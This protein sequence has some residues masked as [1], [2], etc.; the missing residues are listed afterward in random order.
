VP[1]GHGSY[2]LD[3]RRARSTCSTE[4]SGHDYSPLRR[5]PGLYPLPL[6]DLSGCWLFEIS[7]RDLRAR[8]MREKK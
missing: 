5:A 4:M 1:K 2:R 3:A 8:P 6:F 7:I